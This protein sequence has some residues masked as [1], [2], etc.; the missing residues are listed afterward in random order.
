MVKVAIFGKAKTGKDTV[1]NIIVNQLKLT[2]DQYKIAAFASPM[3]HIVETMFPLV[4]KE[5]LY[6][7]SEYRNELVDPNSP[8]LLDSNADPLTIRR[9]L[10]DLGAFARLYN[11]NV[12]VNILSYNLQQEMTDPNKLAFIVSD[13][14]FINEF[15]YLRK[16]NFFLIR[17]KRPG[18][19]KIKNVSETEQDLI[20]DSNFH[21]IINNNSTKGHLIQ[22]V[23]DMIKKINC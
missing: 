5:H 2:S 8:K 17:I 15:N 14:R 11:E 23:S 9:L 4:N 19:T 10:M 21:F 13:G 20:P 18:Y 7:A 6:G 22:Q 1:A 16:E 3:K 12:W